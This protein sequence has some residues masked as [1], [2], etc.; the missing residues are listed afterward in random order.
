M[1]C[2]HSL[3]KSSGLG[4]GGCGPDLAFYIQLSDLAHVSLLSISSLVFHLSVGTNISVW[5]SS[6]GCCEDEK[7]RTILP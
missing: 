6:V 2:H 7:L 1:A 5:P 3:L 4:S